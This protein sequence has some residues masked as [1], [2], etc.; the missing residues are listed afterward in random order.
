MEHTVST[1]RGAELYFNFGI[2]LISPNP[3]DGVR[4]PKRNPKS[5]R[6]FSCL[7]I[8]GVFHGRSI[9]LDH[10]EGLNNGRKSVLPRLIFDNPL[11]S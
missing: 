9:G 11:K 10:L 2:V 7:I 4:V 5:T 6:F 1:S 3:Q 8:Q